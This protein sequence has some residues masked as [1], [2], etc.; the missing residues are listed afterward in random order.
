MY[1]TVQFAQYRQISSLAEVVF[2]AQDRVSV[3]HHT[4]GSPTVIG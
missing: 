3:E 1:Y 4:P 2:V